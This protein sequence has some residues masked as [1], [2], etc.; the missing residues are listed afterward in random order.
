MAKFKVTPQNAN[1]AM[2]SVGI[3]S[4]KTT[5][6]RMDGH[7]S[8]LAKANPTRAERRRIAR[9]EARQRADENMAG[10]NPRFVPMV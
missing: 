10:E 8:D 9:A 1:L 3:E 5:R 6:R 7:K 2:R 4:L